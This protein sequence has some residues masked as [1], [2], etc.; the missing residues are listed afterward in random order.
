VAGNDRKRQI[1]R[2]RYERRMAEKAAA[3]AK[4][5]RRLASGLS[6]GGVVAIAAIALIVVFAVGHKTKK[7]AAAA[8]PSAS[9][10]A[11]ASSSAAVS[12][13]PTSAPGCTSGIAP[14]S[15]TPSPL[16]AGVPTALAQEPTVT[17]P[18]GPVPTTLQ[19]KDIIVGTG[20]TVTSDDSVTVNYV[21]LNY[22]DCKEF[23]SSWSRSTPATFALNGGVIKGFSDGIAGMKVGGR[24]EIIIPPAEGYG[25]TGSSPAIAPNEELVFVVDVLSATKA[26]PSPTASAASTA[27]PTASAASTASPTASAS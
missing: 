8:K 14:A 9:T 27:S 2:Q 23:D 5:K 12:P 19:T 13:A 18:A 16:P 6:A 4:A 26:S 11:P 17:V 25:T 22:V 15:G 7:T 21:G 20:A 1:A 24:R 10:S 3:R